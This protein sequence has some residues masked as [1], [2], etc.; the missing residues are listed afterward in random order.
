MCK[1]LVDEMPT[2]PF[3]CPFAI[4]DI[5]SSNYWCGLTM[6]QNHCELKRVRHLDIHYECPYLRALSEYEDDF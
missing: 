3:D 1:L 5:E 4:S 2:Q 6:P